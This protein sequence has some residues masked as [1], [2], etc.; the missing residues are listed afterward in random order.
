MRKCGAALAMGGLKRIRQRM[1]PETYGGAPLLGLDGCVI[2]IHGRASRTALQH[3]MRQARKFVSLQL[4]EAIVREL[5]R[6]AEV[7]ALDAKLSAK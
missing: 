3:A 4:N 2:K 1:N 7:P 5:A 6:W